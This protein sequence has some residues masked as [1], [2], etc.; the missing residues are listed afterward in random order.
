LTTKLRLANQGDVII[1]AAGE[2]IEDIGNGTAWLGTE[3]VVIHDA[4][5]A[6]KST[7]NPVY[8]SYFLRSKHFKEQ[9]KKHV[10]SGKISSTNAK[11]LGS[12]LIPTPCPENP[13]KS[14]EIQTEIV[15]IL[16]AFTAVTGELTSELAT[17]KKQYNYYR[18]KLLS[19]DEDDVEWKALAELGSFTYGYAAKA[20]DSGDAR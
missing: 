3:D 6:F 15:R 16:D 9:I 20:Q 18:D 5:F 7:L 10:S 17:R 13:K 14:I 4:C 2:T 1:V 12:A 8:V 11:G 19:F